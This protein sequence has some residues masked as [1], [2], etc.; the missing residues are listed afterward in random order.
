MPG[1]LPNTLAYFSDKEKKSFILKLTSG[2]GCWRETRRTRTE[3]IFDAI[4]VVEKPL[5]DLNDEKIL[6]F[7]KRNPS[8]TSVKLFTAVIY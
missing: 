7:E 5:E 6:T 2:F 3:E 1:R 8:A 4:Q